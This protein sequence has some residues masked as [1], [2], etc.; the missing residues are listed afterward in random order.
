MGRVECTLEPPVIPVSGGVLS[1]GPRAEA[2]NRG[3]ACGDVTAEAR[4]RPAV[5]NARVGPLPGR[6]YRYAAGTAPPSAGRPELTLEPAG[7][8]PWRIYDKSAASLE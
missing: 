4:V 7:P 2:W 1:S 6:T 3:P 8:D 5:Q